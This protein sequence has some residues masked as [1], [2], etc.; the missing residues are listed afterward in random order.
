MIEA[1]PVHRTRPAHARCALLIA[2]AVMGFGLLWGAMASAQDAP[3]P[4]Q[5]QADAEESESDAAEGDEA[6]PVRTESGSLDDSEGS[7]TVS[8]VAEG[9]KFRGDMRTGFYASETDDRD[10]TDVESSV[11]SG[12]RWMHRYGGGGALHRCV[13]ALYM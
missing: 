13:W 8:Q 12:R 3:V 11:P 2:L 10:G 5:D 9:W 1:N 7:I 6:G 4:E